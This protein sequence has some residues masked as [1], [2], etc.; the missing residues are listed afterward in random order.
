MGLLLPGYMP[1]GV[2]A[3]MT[4][5]GT[6]DYIGDTETMVFRLPFQAAPKRIYRVH[7]VAYSADTDGTGDNTNANI[8]YAKNSMIIR[9]RWASGSTV[10]TSGTAFGEYRVAVFDD[11]S[12]TSSGADVAF[13][14][15]NPPAGQLTVGVSIAT[16]RAA[17]TYGQVRFL[18]GAMS[19]LVVEDVGPY[20]E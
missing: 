16:A 9:G 10:S 6:T 4:N 7:L 8:R 13:Y 18:A 11:D 20:S 5:L 17:A 14:L 19:A 3:I 15:V 12:S 1:R 2:V